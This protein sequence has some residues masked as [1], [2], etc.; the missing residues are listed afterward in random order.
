MLAEGDQRGMKNEKT[1]IH[2][3][4]VLPALRAM[5]HVG[6]EQ[7][8]RIGKIGLQQEADVV[9]WHCTMQPLRRNVHSY[10]LHSRH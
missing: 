9:S 1:T 6:I 10:A 7:F 2:T 8:V 5:G 4:K 3:T